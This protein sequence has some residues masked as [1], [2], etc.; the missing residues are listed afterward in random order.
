MV[1]T[2]PITSSTMTTAATPTPLG[3][4][5]PLNSINTTAQIPLK[6]TPPNYS[7]WR[8]QF[9]SLLIGYYFL[10]FVDD[11]KPRPQPTLTHNGATIPNPDLSLWICQ[12]QLL[13]NEIIS[14]LTPTLIPFIVASTSS[15]DAWTT[16]AKTYAAPSRGRILQLK[17]N[18]PIL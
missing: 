9:H 15:S 12:D 14:Y 1:D 11:S 17:T 6:L 18:L 13:L 2:D 16:L 3:S 10:G 5:P 8:L 4:F 7:A